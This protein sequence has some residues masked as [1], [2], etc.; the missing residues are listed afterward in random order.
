MKRQ[1]IWNL[2]TAIAIAFLVLGYFIEKDNTNIVGRIFII[3]GA[4]IFVI[5]IVGS[6]HVHK[7]YPYK[8]PVCGSEIKPV[9]RWLPGVGFNGTDTV[10]C[11]HCGSVIHI[12]D[13]SQE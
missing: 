1:K 12:Q 8:C 5:S 9:G 13:L 2:L 3:F 10:T 11:A 4:I 7:K 6:S